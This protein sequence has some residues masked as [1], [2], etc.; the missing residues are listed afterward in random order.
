MVSE[1]VGGQKNEKLFDSITLMV[2]NKKD[3]MVF[4]ERLNE[5]K[6]EFDILKKVSKLQSDQILKYIDCIE[7]A[8]NVYIITEDYEDGIDNLL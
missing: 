6:K 8:N 5:I 2:Y 1:K 4:I 7:S 3:H